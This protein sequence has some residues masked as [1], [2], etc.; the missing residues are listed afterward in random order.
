MWNFSP[1]TVS[2]SILTDNMF[3]A[4]SLWKPQRNL[5]QFE[6][7]LFVQWLPNQENSWVNIWVN[8]LAISL[9]GPRIPQYARLAKYNA[10]PL[11]PFIE[12]LPKDG[13]WLD[14][15]G[16]T[17]SPFG[18]SGP[19]ISAQG[20]VHYTTSFPT[21]GQKESERSYRRRS[22]GSDRT[23]GARARGRAGAWAGERTGG[24]WV[25]VRA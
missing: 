2:D 24:G 18:V 7:S 15:A 12:N 14:T 11:S 3:Y 10:I 23:C 21:T 9:A 22:A 19:S 20:T 5:F 8:I 17:P 16:M 13:T 4:Q 1:L 6:F 25:G